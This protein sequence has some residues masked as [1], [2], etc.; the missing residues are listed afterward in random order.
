VARTSEEKS[1]KRGCI[2]AGRRE[3]FAWKKGPRC[4]ATFIRGKQFFRVI[5]AAN[6]DKR[7]KS[8]GGSSAGWARRTIVVSIWQFGQARVQTQTASRRCRG[9]DLFVRRNAKQK[10]PLAR[11]AHPKREKWAAGRG[12]KNT[13]V[14]RRSRTRRGQK[15]SALEPAEGRSHD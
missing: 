13:D 4:S 11:G 2:D 6:V 8:K 1:L 9:V 10:I 7:V 5:L 15:G 3:G 12:E 14:R